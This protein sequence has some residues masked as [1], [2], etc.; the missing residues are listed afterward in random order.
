MLG[1]VHLGFQAFAHKLDRTKHYCM[2]HMHYWWR[3]SLLLQVK[4]DCRSPT[5]TRSPCLGNE[6]R[7][8]VPSF[9]TE[10]GNGVAGV[11]KGGI[12]LKNGVTTDAKQYFSDDIR[13]YYGETGTQDALLD[14]EA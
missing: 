8:I 6:A 7:V 13:V 10:T 5:S 9:V 12:Y 14:L 3:S 4:E 1:C 11:A 2:M